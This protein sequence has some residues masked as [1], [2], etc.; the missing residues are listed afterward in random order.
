VLSTGGLKHA[1]SRAPRAAR[2]QILGYCVGVTA[3][4]RLLALLSAPVFCTA[5]C[6]RTS[7]TELTTQ[8]R[9]AGP[10]ADAAPSVRPVDA[11]AAPADAGPASA[12]EAGATPTRASVDGPHYLPLSPDRPIYYAFPAGSAFAR[13]IGVFHGM[14]GPPSYACGK[15]LEAAVDVGAVVCP[16]GN[17]K[18]GDSQ[19]GPPSWEAPSWGELVVAMDKD[20]EQSVSRVIA[21]HPK[22]IRREGAILT[23]YSRGAYAAPVVASMHPGRWPYLIL[24]EADVTLTVQSL[25]R[26]RVRAVALVAG[27]LGTE[28]AGMRKTA[29]T[30]AAAGY[31]ARLFVMPKTGHLY[32]E[33]ME[34]VMAS[35]LAFVLQHEPDAG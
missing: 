32:S 29:E 3:P 17:A 16:T 14:C 9:A 13:L 25:E 6:T 18:C 21:K 15:W 20:L 34:E 2:E 30:L 11:S 31:P 22:S 12:A 33:N 28:I 24:I 35:A 26:S 1:P 4:R 5:A 8:G 19:V 23:G 27:E 10:V 7:Q